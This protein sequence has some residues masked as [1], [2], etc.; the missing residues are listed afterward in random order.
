MKLAV[1]AACFLLACFKKA[2]KVRE[3]I[4]QITGRKSG[5]IVVDLEAKV[6]GCCA[7]LPSEDVEQT[8]H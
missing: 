8:V 7:C 1:I 3:L 6:A 4:H 2:F 5:V